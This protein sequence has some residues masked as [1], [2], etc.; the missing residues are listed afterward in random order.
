MTVS[1]S[2]TGAP[3]CNNNLQTNYEQPFAVYLATVVSNLSVVDGVHSI[4]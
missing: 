4:W 2:V 1:G 3:G